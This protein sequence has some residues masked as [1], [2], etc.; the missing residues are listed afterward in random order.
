[1]RELRNVLEQAVLLGSGEVIDVQHLAL[2]SS[3]FNGIEA[4]PMQSPA[5]LAAAEAAPA[6]LPELERTALLKALERTGWNV[7]RAARLLGISRDA[8]RYRIDKYG[9]DGPG[10]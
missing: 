5:R 10:A 2:P 1:V 8:L 4:N 3:V 9:L 6:T 7:S